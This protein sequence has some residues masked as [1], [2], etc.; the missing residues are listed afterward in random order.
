MALYKWNDSFKIGI[1][2]IDNQH[3]KLF[4]MIDIYYQSF[5]KGKSKEGLVI[6]VQ[7]LSDYTEFHFKFE[8]NYFKK[9]D[10]PKTE[11][12]LIEHK[13]FINDLEDFKLR[14]NRNKMVLPVEVGNFLGEWLLNH[15]K[16]SDRQYVKLFK[17]NNIK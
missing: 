13:R 1:D 5:K 14:I 17:E 8:E 16:G 6:L 15:I 4:E 10:Y 11:E 3:K 9:Y 7:E 2:S 12:H